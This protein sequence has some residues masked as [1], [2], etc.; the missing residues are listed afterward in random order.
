MSVPA[1]KISFAKTEP[2][3]SYVLQL[4]ILVAAFD[5]STVLAADRMQLAQALPGQVV[6]QG[7]V[8]PIPLTPT[9]LIS[10]QTNTACLVSCDTQVMNCQNA[11]VV[12]GPTIGAATPP[13]MRLAI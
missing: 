12:V 2:S 13:A 4:S 1:D 5:V 9:P 11:C 8:V 3:M 10:S 6:P 7:Q